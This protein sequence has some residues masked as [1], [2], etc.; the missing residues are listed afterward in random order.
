[1]NPEQYY[2]R[3]VMIENIKG[4]KMRTDTLFFVSDFIN[5]NPTY[6]LNQ[7]YLFGTLLFV[8]SDEK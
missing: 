7:S 1:M 4:K 5:C 6:E 8:N 2:S 3:V